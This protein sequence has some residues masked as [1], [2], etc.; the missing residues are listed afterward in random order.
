MNIAASTFAEILSKQFPNSE[1]ISAA[2]LT[3]GVSADVFKLEYQQDTVPKSVVLRIH[4]DT[5][6]G[7]PAQ[8][9]FDLLRAIHSA[10]IPSAKPLAVDASGDI[11]PEPYLLLEFVSGNT[12]VAPEFVDQAIT[13]MAEALRN[14]HSSRPEGLPKLPRRTEPMPEMLAWLIDPRWDELKSF[15]KNVQTQF[16]G[17]DRLLHGDY[18][19]EN[20]MWLDNQVN[21]ILDWEDAA[22]GDPLSDIACCCLELSYIYGFEIGDKFHIAYGGEVDEERFLLWQIYVASAAA[23]YMEHWGLPREKEAHMRNTAI[24]FIERAAGKLMQRP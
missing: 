10:S 14:I 8:L 21:A 24:A 13:L 22:I 11:L 17:G 18:W 4:G 7:H 1:F 19:P 23:M 5:H 12:A 6:G 20:V 2:R 16:T 9:E 3:G 15:L